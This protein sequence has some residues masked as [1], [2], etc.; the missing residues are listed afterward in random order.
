MATS[1]SQDLNELFMSLSYKTSKTLL[2]PYV[3]PEIT[4]RNN[5]IIKILNSDGSL[6]QALFLMDSNDYTNNGINDYDYI[7]DDQV[8]WYENNVLSLQEQYGKEA[9]SML[10]FHIPLQEYRTANDLYEKDDTQVKY[11]FG[12]IGETMINKICCSN[13]PSK[14][15]DTAVSLNSTKAMFCGHDH[16]NNISLEYKGIRLTY[17]M[18]IDYLAMPGIENDMK[19]RGAT[20]I[21]LHEDS[22]FDIEQIKLTEIE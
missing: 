11:F 12:E 10:F 3:Q 1:S 16:Y 14:L 18:S 6:N 15:F 20:L 8:D 21:T 22:S 4:G 9:S 5:Q 2:Y 19:Q 7:H 17:G 13:Y